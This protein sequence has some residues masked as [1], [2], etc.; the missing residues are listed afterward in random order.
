MK[1][2]ILLLCLLIPFKVYSMS[3]SSYI[4][5][6]ASSK[7]IL[8][9]YKENDKHLIASTSKI[10]TAIIA[11]EYGNLNDT[12]EV[13]DEIDTSEGSSLYLKKGEKI[14]LKDL[15]Y[16]LMLR[17]GN[18]AALI[19]AKNIGGNVSN[20]VDMMNN[21]AQD[22][23]MKNTTF[24]NPHG[25]ENNKG[26]GNISTAYDMALLMSYAIDNK[27]FLKIIG[28]KKYHCKT[29]ERS[30]LWHNK[31]RLLSEYKYLL[32]GKTGYTKKARRTLVT[33]AL[34]D[35]KKL[36]IVT[37]QDGNDFNDHKYLYETYFNRYN[38]V[39][40]LNK[41]DYVGNNR[42]YILKDFK[43][44]MT[45]EEEDNYK[46]EYDIDNNNVGLIGQANVLVNNKKIASIPIYR[47]AIHN[48][49]S[50]WNYIF[51]IMRKRYA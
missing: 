49:T 32:G 19:I 38:L 46:L 50:F 44:L 14:K 2:L 12:Y 29:N 45:K 18:D 42:E 51:H 25:L 22:L 20:F 48:P 33:A 34:K 37:L 40:I 47:E 4:V 23:D 6:D 26:E 16:G 13:G 1:K 28:T 30:F 24:I 27:N 36:V 35:N 15:L 31:N 10:M 7:R 41:K 5:M 11:L 39:N 8:H 43:V 21:K 17:S 3:A 9:G